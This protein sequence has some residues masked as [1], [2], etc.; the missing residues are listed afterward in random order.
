MNVA[1]RS[2]PS[3]ACTRQRTTL[4]RKYRASYIVCVCVCVC[5][6]MY[7]HTP[8]LTHFPSNRLPPVDSVRANRPPCTFFIFIFIIETARAQRISDRH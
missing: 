7:L 2:P 8:A 5:V 3:C 1:P 6:C 4:R